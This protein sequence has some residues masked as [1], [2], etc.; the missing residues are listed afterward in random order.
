ML[1]DPDKDT[2]TPKDLD[3]I[4]RLRRPPQPVVPLEKVLSPKELEERLER[5]AKEAKERRLRTVKTPAAKILVEVADEAKL[6]V[7]TITTNLEGL[8]SPAIVAARHKAMY[9]MFIE[10]RYSFPRIG[11]FFDGANH[12]TVMYGVG[13]HALRNKLPAPQSCLRLARRM[14]VRQRETTNAQ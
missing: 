5:E 12:A 3:R 14:F 8:R 2:W 11:H 13:A 6:R 7:D 10:L 4:R 1:F 9:R